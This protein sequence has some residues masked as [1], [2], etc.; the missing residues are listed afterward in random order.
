MPKWLLRL[1]YISLAGII[2]WPLVCFC[3]LFMFDDPHIDVHQ[4]TI[5]FILLNCYPVLLVLL[6]WLSFRTFRVNHK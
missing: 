1:N 3:S 2:A 5:W 4:T 6:S